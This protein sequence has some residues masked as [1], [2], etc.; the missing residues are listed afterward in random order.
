VDNV[1]FFADGSSKQ[2]G[3]LECR[4]PDIAEIVRFEEIARCLL[5]P[6]PQRGIR[7]QDVASAFDGAKL[8]SMIRHRLACA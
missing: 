6:I 4:R 7:R 2:I 1:G 5:E 3:V 8:A